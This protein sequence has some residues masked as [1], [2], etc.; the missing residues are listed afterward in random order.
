MPLK[1]GSSKDIISDNISTEMHAGKPQPQAI[2]IAY[3]KAGKSLKKDEIPG[4]LADDKT[5]KDF[6]E[7]DLQEGMKVEMEHT[8]DKKIA[9]EIAMDHL[10]ED[11]HYYKKLKEVEK[12]ER[13]R[14]DKEPDGKQEFDFGT[15]ELDKDAQR[16]AQSSNQDAQNSRDVS[17]KILNMRKRWKTLKKAMADKSFMSIEDETKSD[18]QP[19]QPEA[20]QDQG[21][22]SAMG[23]DEINSLLSQVDQP[24]DQNPNDGDSESATQSDTQ[25]SPQQDE[26]KPEELEETM[27]ELGYSSSEIAHIIHGL[28]LPDVDEVK[29]E[30]AKTENAKRQ[31]ELSLQQ[32]EMQIK[33]GEHALKSGHAEKLNT[34]DADHKKQALDSE[35][36]HAK[37]M[38]EL[39]YAKAKKAADAEDDTEHKK[40]LRDIEYEKAKKDIPGDKFDD[41]E[42]QKCMME[43]ELQERQLDLEQKKQEVKLEIEFKKKEMEFKLK[44]AEE[45]AKKKLKEKLAEPPTPTKKLK[46]SEEEC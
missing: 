7:K 11:K 9:R 44:H 3:S 40:R 37:R 16:A 38:K 10:T 15:E 42:H 6:D 30:K 2:A 8:S 27:K 14:I 31:G 25:A 26:V 20:Q 32:L 5:P 29:Q 46:K 13:I 43:I 33:Q 23:E 4:G 22:Q 28:H 12:N 35:L 39:E 45:M 36:E 21:S 24:T 1:L 18:E 17:I 41:T 19:Q 34:L